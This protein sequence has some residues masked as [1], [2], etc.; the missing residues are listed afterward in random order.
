MTQLLERVSRDPLE[1]V[2]RLLENPKVDPTCRNNKPISISCDQIFIYK[3]TFNKSPPK[4]N[5]HH[6]VLKL[7]LADGRAN[8][9]AQNNVLME[10]SVLYKCPRILKILLDD[11]RCDPSQN[12]N[13]FLQI[14]INKEMAEIKNLLLR[15][16]RV[17]K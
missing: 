13:E 8:P 1:I 9:A 12:E 5:H 3:D 11:G 7:M 14:S 15:D 10:Q 2:R 17:I 4:T 16:P 6:Q